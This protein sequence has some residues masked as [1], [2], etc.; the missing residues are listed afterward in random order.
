MSDELK[1]YTASPLDLIHG[2]VSRAETSYSEFERGFRNLADVEKERGYCREIINSN[3]EKIKQASYA[4]GLEDGS[5]RASE[6]IFKLVDSL[7][8]TPD[9]IVYEDYCTYNRK[10]SELRKKYCPEKEQQQHDR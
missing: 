2:V 8:E 7:Y 5:R 3:I 1:C 6:E 9:D 10:Y 4:K